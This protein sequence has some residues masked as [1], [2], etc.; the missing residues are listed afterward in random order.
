MTLLIPLS[1]S[2]PYQSLSVALSGRPYKLSLL[3][4]ELAQYW[5][6]TIQM[7]DG[8]VLLRNIKMV[9]NYPL[10]K[11]FVDDRLPNGELVFLNTD[12]YRPDFESVGGNGALYF[13]EK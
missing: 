8:T 2:E 7:L 6:I 5:S 11:N 1:K 9:Q 3:W 10:L 12:T 4:N 13:I